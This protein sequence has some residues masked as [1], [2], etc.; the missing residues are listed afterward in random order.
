MNGLLGYNDI[1]DIIVSR[2]GFHNLE[3]YRNYLENPLY[4][5]SPPTQEEIDLLSPDNINCRDFWLVCDNLFGTDPVCN[6]SIKRYH[7]YREALG[8]TYANRHN[9][10]LAETFNFLLYL[11]EFSFNPQH[12]LVEIG[13][14]YGSL[15]GWVEANTKFQYFGFDVVPR[16]PDIQS[17]TDQGTFPDN[18][19]KLDDR[20]NYVVSSNVF[21]HLSEKQRLS[22]FDDA[23]KLLV[24]GGL[25]M[26]NGFIDKG[27][28]YPS[29]TAAGKI[30]CVHYGQLTP[31]MTEE[32]V[33]TELEKRGFRIHMKVERW[34]YVTCFIAQ[35]HVPAT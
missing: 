21:Q 14:G 9:L 34:D 1:K 28:D 24:P 33:R 22:Y 6:V 4:G 2:Y 16:L 12:V 25:F 32:W 17:L 8:I 18:I 5:K 3:T 27:A 20:V 35:K 7:S 19:H 10:W 30:Y 26:F 23:Q 13:S 11:R 15:K 31:Y 29:R